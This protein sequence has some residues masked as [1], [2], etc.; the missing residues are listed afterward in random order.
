MLICRLTAAKTF[1]EDGPHALMAGPICILLRATNTGISVQNRSADTHCKLGINDLGIEIQTH[2]IVQE[3]RTGLAR[4]HLAENVGST[5][6]ITITV[7]LRGKFER[8]RLYA[9]NIL[10]RLR[11]FNGQTVSY[12]CTQAEADTMQ[13]PA[14]A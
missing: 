1:G 11:K 12:F 14:W 2:H 6:H 3:C 10:C 9:V 5:K 8:L 13:P 7:N 4:E